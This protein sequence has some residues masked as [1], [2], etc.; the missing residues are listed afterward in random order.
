MKA[1]K[2]ILIILVAIL[3]IVFVMSLMGDDTYR[4]ERSV[5]VKA[6]VEVVYAHTNT[7]AAMDKWS[8]WNDHDPNM[9]KSMS[10]TDGTIGAI[11]SWEG[12]SDV[13]SGS[14]EIV[15]LEPN[16]K[17]GVA[18]H[19]KEPMESES[20]AEVLLEGLG[21]STK[22]TWAMF[23]NNDGMIAKAMSM[24]FNMD[25][26]VGPEFEKGLGRLK[27]QAEAAATSAPKNEFRGYKVDMVDRPEMVYVGKRAMVKWTDMQK[28]YGD[29]YQ[30]L[31]KDL[32]AAKLEMA[33]MPSGIIF[34]WDEP[35]QQADM[36]AAMPVKGDAT[37]SVKGWETLVVPAGKAQFIPYMG[38]YHGSY[39]AH[40]AMDDAMKANG[41]ELNL[42]VIE[43][44]ITDPM[45]EPDSMKWLT[46][47]YYMMK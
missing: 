17:V 37:T 35:N 4:V 22:V 15:A 39:N 11:A 20:N 12:N 32:G 7:L 28:F 33:G 46:N 14:Q 3:A 16:K 26:M 24:F 47:I 18:L 41:R 23:G 8:P 42:H 2:T 27:E 13:G 34:K 45:S 44:Y 21:D 19:F 1:L 29:T 38:G 10:G 5:T 30:A 36:M 40:M 6:P 9:K 25:K 43:E 31:G